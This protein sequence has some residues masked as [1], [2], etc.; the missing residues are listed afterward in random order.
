MSL[1]NKAEIESI[2]NTLE[3]TLDDVVNYLRNEITG[4]TVI[5]IKNGQK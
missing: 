2:E 5:Q 3:R 4:G 1:F